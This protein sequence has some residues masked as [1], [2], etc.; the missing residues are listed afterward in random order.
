MIDDGGTT[1]WTDSPGFAAVKARIL[2]PPPLV[3]DLISQLRD[4]PGKSIVKIKVGD[5]EVPLT[6]V[7]IVGSLL[8]CPDEQTKRPSQRYEP[9]ITAGCGKAQVQP[10]EGL[11]RG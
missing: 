11:R 6:N 1:I 7:D 10:E 9:E 5:A 8:S 4:T 2:R 3:K